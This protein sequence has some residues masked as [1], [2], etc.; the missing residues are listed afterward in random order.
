[1]LYKRTNVKTGLNMKKTKHWLFDFDG[2]L[3]GSM[4]YWSACMV[5]VLDNHGIPY[6]DDIVNIITPLGTNGTIEYFQKIGLAL[7]FDEIKK[8]IFAGLVPLYRDVIPEKEGVRACLEKMREAG[9]K[10]HILTASPHVYLDPCLE[11]LGMYDL[12]D[13]VW[14]SDDFGTGKTDPGIYHSVAEKLG[15][16]VSDIT[17]LDDN[18]N[19]DKAAKLA[20]TQV[21]AVYDE[22]SR[23]DEG[24]MRE[25]CD[26]YVYDFSELE[27]I[28]V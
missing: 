2:T 7:P 12:F 5:G 18:I 1:M 3:V 28:V 4:P 16:T 10:L 27:K 6:G 26:G 9:Y 20:G 23:D 19:A 13:N 24:K 21:I 8:E 17:F 14:S 22:T 11:R 15:T 25:I